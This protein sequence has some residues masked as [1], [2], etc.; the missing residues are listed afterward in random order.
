MH[1][2]QYYIH[3]L[4]PRVFYTWPHSQGG[5]MTKLVS[6]QITIAL[7]EARIAL[8]IA[9]TMHIQSTAATFSKCL[10]LGGWVGVVYDCLRSLLDLH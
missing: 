8:I 3:S 7:G 4:I 1:Y 5:G 9:R 6:K 10:T 2:V